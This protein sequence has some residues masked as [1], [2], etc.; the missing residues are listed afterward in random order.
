MRVIYCKTK[1]SYMEEIRLAI[2]GKNSLHE[3]MNSKL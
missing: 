1:S 3:Y 2:T